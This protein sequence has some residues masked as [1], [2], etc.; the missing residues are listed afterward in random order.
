MA[1]Q[2]AERKQ[3]KLKIAVT[4]PSGSGKTYSSLLIA[5]GLGR[6]IAVAD[7]ENRS[8]SL[9]ADRFEFDTEVIEPPYTIQKYLDAITA[10]ERAGYDVLVIDS[11]THA[12]AAEG[13]LLSKKE[14]LDARGGNSYTNWASITKEH[15]A[16]KARLLN[17]DVHLICTMRS[18]QDYVLE[19]NEKGKSQPRKVGLAPI[20][21]DGMEYEFTTVLD[22]SMTHEAQA[23]K[24]RTGLFDGRIFKP[25]VETGREL[26]KWLN[27]GK[28]SEANVAGIQPQAKLTEA[29]PEQMKNMLAAFAKVGVTPLMIESKYGPKLTLLAVEEL[30]EIHGALIR[31][32]QVSAYFPM[33]SGLVVEDDLFDAPLPPPQDTPPP[34]VA[35]PPVK[36]LSGD[37]KAKA[38]KEMRERL[39]G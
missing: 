13:G 22:V 33:E 12:W 28:P 23:S 19:V 20:Q 18:K 8:A 15:E 3:A 36:P 1:F 38:I 11:I 9:Y 25:T 39:E 10:A 14:S 31:G 32:A 6:K 26:L 5:Q 4:G 24:D 35:K 29:T 16:F 37:A 7:T 27:E 21:R 17:C 2:K 30:R 34:V